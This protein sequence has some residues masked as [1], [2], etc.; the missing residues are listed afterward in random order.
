MLGQL[1]VRV[2]G[3]QLVK[4]DRNEVFEAGGDDGYRRAHQCSR[5]SRGERRVTFLSP[6]SP[7]T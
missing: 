3:D 5:V 7:D 4:A 6:F 1:Q 2:L